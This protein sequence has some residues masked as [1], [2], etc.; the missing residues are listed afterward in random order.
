M[1]LFQ[2]FG[3]YIVHTFFQVLPFAFLAIVGVIWWITQDIKN[4]HNEND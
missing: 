4:N 2:E 1:L 3:R